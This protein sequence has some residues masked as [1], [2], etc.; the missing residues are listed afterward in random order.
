M[1]T[2][3]ATCVFGVMVCV[4]RGYY[5]GGVIGLSLVVSSLLLFETYRKWK[6]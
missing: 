3:K 4:E 5:F 6:L 2:I 1:N